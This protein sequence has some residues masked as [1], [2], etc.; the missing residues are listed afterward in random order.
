MV[1]KKV[2]LGD[3]FAIALAAVA[4]LFLGDVQVCRSRLVKK[5]IVAVCAMWH[6]FAHSPS[7]W[8]LSLC[9]LSDY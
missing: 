4:F 9:F 1:M 7:L 8:P 3:F 5:A 2:A 6:P